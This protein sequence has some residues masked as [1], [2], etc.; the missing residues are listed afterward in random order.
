MAK[1]ASAKKK[2]KSPKESVTVQKLASTT[3]AVPSKRGRGRPPKDPNAP[4]AKKKRGKETYSRF[5]YKVLKQVHPD[6]GISAK[7]MSIMNSFCNEMF[8]KLAAEA[9]KLA[10]YNKSKTISSR[11]IQTGQEIVL[12]LL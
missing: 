4:N 11:D 12:L 1:S 5:I 10:R 7:S 8:E 3:A 2:D 9:S 6:T